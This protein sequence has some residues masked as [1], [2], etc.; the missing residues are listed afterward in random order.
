[1]IKKITNTDQIL[2]QVVKYRMRICCYTA[3]LGLQQSRQY[4]GRPFD[5]TE[6]R[7]LDGTAVRFET[8]FFRK[9]G[10]SM[11]QRDFQKI[12]LVY[13]TG[14][15]RGKNFVQKLGQRMHGIGLISFEG[16]S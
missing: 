3:A 14:F 7:C 13:M 16:D 1:M 12:F 8:T 11:V 10:V 2:K 15:L 6:K 4:R 9:R 5:G